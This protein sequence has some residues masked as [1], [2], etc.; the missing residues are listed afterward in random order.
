MQ[1]LAERVLAVAPVRFNLVGL[2]MGGY[3]A[4]EILRRSPERVARLALLSTTARPDTPEQTERRTAQMGL[5]SDGKF[6]EVVD[7]LFPILFR[8]A[9][10]SDAALRELTHAM[11]RECGAEAFVRQLTAIMKRPDSRPDLAKIA[12]PTLVLVGEDDQ[13]TPLD[14]AEEMVAAIP[15]ARLVAVADCG[16]LST[17]DQPEAVTAALTWWLTA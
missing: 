5:A 16:H 2:S 9:R 10:N 3:L 1:A 11:A 4:F 13:I 15:D 8:P 6:A 17:L 14:R 7:A 12:C